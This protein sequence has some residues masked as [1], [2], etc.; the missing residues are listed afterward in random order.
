MAP[1]FVY[2][3]HMNGGIRGILNS[4]RYND[5]NLV[6]YSAKNDYQI[7][8]TEILADK[9]KNFRIIDKLSEL[10]KSVLEAIRNNSK[11]ATVNFPIAFR[12]PLV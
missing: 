6:D 10:E 2:I 5:I 12:T 3:A 11:N 7:I 9:I 8:L 4:G 1:E